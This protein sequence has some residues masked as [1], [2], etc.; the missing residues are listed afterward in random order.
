M[1]SNHRDIHC[2]NS[3]PIRAERTIFSNNRNLPNDSIQCFPNANFI[4]ETLKGNEIGFKDQN[5]PACNSFRFF[6]R[7][8]FLQLGE[9]AGVYQCD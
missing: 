3:N 4:Y 8:S 7:A 5:M 2:R 1:D 6:S 9:F